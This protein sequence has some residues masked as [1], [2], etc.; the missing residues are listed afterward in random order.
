MSFIS[1]R[2]STESVIRYLIAGLRDG[3]I[4]LD[5]E[6]QEE[7]SPVLKSPSLDS[8]L[9]YLIVPNAETVEAEVREP[10]RLRS[11]K[12]R[13]LAM[14]FV[15]QINDIFLKH[16]QREGHVVHARLKRRI[17]LLLAK[18]EDEIKAIIKSDTEGTAE[19][20]VAADLAKTTA[21]AL[22]LTI[23]H[24]PDDLFWAS[25]YIQQLINVAIIASERITRPAVAGLIQ[26]YIKNPRQQYA[27]V[28]GLATIGEPAVDVL[29]E[30]LSHPIEEMRMIAARFL[31]EIGNIRALLPLVEA[32]KHEVDDGVRE[33]FMIA[34]ERIRGNAP[35]AVSYSV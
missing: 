14:Y 17:N 29:I 10:E 27:I 33:T 24:C 2:H 18:L 1:A 4:V 21:H 23:E 30:Y 26:A 12:P 16:R 8:H 35:S 19:N 22:T 11:E 15:Q 32:A 6:D 31:G 25:I 7:M 3:S 9:H 28:N 34:I 13:S 5:H 20:D